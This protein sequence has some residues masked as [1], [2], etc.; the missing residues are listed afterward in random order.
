VVLFGSLSGSSVIW[1]GW[2]DF[3]K[4][5]GVP[6]LIAIIV[7]TQLS[8]KIDRGIQI[9]DHVDAELQYLAIRGCAPAVGTPAVTELLPTPLLTP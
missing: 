7:L 3:A 5:V 8:P 4:T 2:T 6:A 9:A 1:Q